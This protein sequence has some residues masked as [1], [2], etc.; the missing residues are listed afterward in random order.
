MLDDDADVVRWVWLL[1]DDSAP[2]PTALVELLRAADRER[3]VEVFGPKLR[4]WRNRDV[5]V[6]C[7]VTVARSGNRVTGL[8]RH[9]LDQGQH[10]DVGDVLAVSSAGMLVRRDV[11]DALGGFDPALAMFRDDVDFCWRARRSGARVVVATAAVVHHREAATHGRRPVD[12]GSPKH[13]DRPRRI[14][15]V[16]AIHLLRAQTAGFHRVL[17]TLRLLVGS[18]LRALGL[19]VGKAPQEARD[20]WGAFRDA[21]LDRSGLQASRARVTAASALPGAVPASDVRSFLA[22]RGIQ[23][24][25]ALETVG[26]LVAGRETADAQRSVLDST[27]D[28]PDGWYADDRR[29]SRIRR[30]VSRPG[31]L[32]VLGLLAFA[33][34]GVR[35]LFGE[36]VLQGGALLP[37][38]DGVG[39]LWQSYLTA[40]HE[41]GPGSAADSPAWLVPL[42]A[43]ALVLRGSTSW[44]VDALLLGLVPLAGASSY[45][46]MRGVVS[47]TVDPGRRGRDLRHAARRDG[48]HLGWS[49]R[50]RGV[51]RAAPVARALV[52]TPRRSGSGPDVATR[53][54]HVDAAR[55]GDGVHPCGLGDGRRARSRRGRRARARRSRAVAPA[56]HRAHAGRP[57]GA[58]EP[59]RRTRTCPA[60]ARAR[61]RRAGRHPPR[62]L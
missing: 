56:R 40:W 45:L 24:R 5:L 23:A 34:V 31:T 6:E 49:P 3:T 41:V 57:A 25:H 55:P 4:G 29:P 58:V 12:A 28:D 17:V 37:M 54:R 50:H 52:R 8:E 48:R 1:H 51:D 14:D 7:G 11:W 9:E 18:L 33:L 36:G 39:D 60:A 32:L 44:A 30:F 61:D 10:D 16:A 47:S 38:P 15:R 2:A 19:L 43:L 35:G 53:V 26:D 21:I 42:S 62:A 13:P 20:E 46:A 59:S 27:P 22:P